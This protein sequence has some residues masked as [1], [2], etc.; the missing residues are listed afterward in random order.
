MRW[1]RLIG[2]LF[3]VFA[4]FGI[5][6][7]AWFSSNY[8]ADLPQDLDNLADFRPPTAC[9]ITDEAGNVLDSFYLER[10]YPVAD[11]RDPSFP[12]YVW[13]AF[14][15]AED[16]R[17]FEHPGVDA[18]GILR[19]IVVNARAG[20]T[21]EGGSTLTQQLVKNI[22]LTNEKS[23][24]R[25]IKEA[26]L[27]WRMERKLNKMEILR[28]Y[29]D[30]IYLGSGN[31]G[32]EA[33]ARD[34]FGKTAAE[35]E[36]HEIATI[37]A[38]IPAPS[39]Y[40]PRTNPKEALRRRRLVLRAMVEEGFLDAKE[41]AEKWNNEPLVLSP[42]GRGEDRG[43]KTA[44]ITVVRREIQK[45]YGSNATIDG[46][47]IV[48]PYNAAV[49][50]VAVRATREAAEAHLARQGPRPI[51]LRSGS[52]PPFPDGECF[53]VQVDGD[54]ATLRAGAMTYSLV[55][56]DRNVRVFDE[57]EDKFPSALSSQIRGGEI[58]AVCLAEDH[59]EP[60]IDGRPW[61]TID[62]SPWAQSAAVVL[63]HPTGRVVTVTGGI[64]PGQLEG[65]VRGVQAE[66][67]PGSSFK[68]Y[69]YA[70]ALSLGKSQLDIMV[71]RPIRIG[72]WAPQNYGKSFRGRMPI[73][74]ALTRSTNTIAVQ[75]ML[76]AGPQRVA[77]LARALGVQTPLRPDLTMALG[78]SEVTPLD[79]ATGYAGL[80]R[81]GVPTDAIFVLRVEDAAGGLIAKAGEPAYPNGPRLPGSPKPRALDAGVAAETLDMM[82][83]VVRFG[84]GRR[85]YRPDVDRAGKTGTTNSFVDAWF[86]G[87]TPE[88]TI[89]VWVGT[90]GYG[91]LGDRETGGK[92]SLPAWIQI[93]D[94]LMEYETE[95]RFP[96]PDEVVMVTWQGQEV[97]MRRGGVHD[98]VLPLPSLGSA[99][100]ATVDR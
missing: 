10:R 42:G 91:T 71:D 37:A 81:G 74:M 99:P 33:A 17:F 100:L 51:K 46:L 88:H 34:Y 8:L 29:M 84:T 75:L 14:V 16:R 54:L 57:R 22:L 86:V 48:T 11:I 79:Q 43:A 78:T 39:H 61:V 92:A 4:A 52:R 36:P 82:K 28:L 63:H 80:A 5:G 56:S 21:V 7:F 2:M 27:A 19:A 69:V 96:I 12:K 98:S 66:R 87:V 73:R 38:L 65:F 94:V 41:V 24:D 40:S 64:G 53:R 59:D 1:F 13:Q 72:N 97:A 93:A 50:E 3:F 67:Q 95:T 47:K 60:P 18:L 68:P 32:V 70:S 90:D 44:Y 20:R 76:E 26:V 89:A 85:A 35:L 77:G 45:Y 30:F 25:K 9:T 23:I 31:Y 58:L 55:P 6:G 15:A 83:S 49:Q 62:K